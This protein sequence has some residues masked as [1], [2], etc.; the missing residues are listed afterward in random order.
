[1]Q[2]AQNLECTDALLHGAMCFVLVPI[3][4]SVTITDDSISVRLA[5]SSRLCD[6]ISICMTVCVSIG[7]AACRRTRAIRVR[8]V[9]DSVRLGFLHGCLS[10][11]ASRLRQR[12]DQERG[13]EREK[14][15][16]EHRRRRIHVEL[17]TR[18]SE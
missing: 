10:A 5:V 17:V 14:D 16:R 7:V 6:S 9:G 3:S 1:M 4:L 13:F 15:K 18:C 11:L 2:P 12:E 8:T